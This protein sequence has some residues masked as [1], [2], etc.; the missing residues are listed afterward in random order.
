M[1]AYRPAS[2]FA[3]LAINSA[4]SAIK[5][6]YEN[7]QIPDRLFYHVWAHT[8]GVIGRATRIATALKLSTPFVTIVQTAAAK[9]DEVQLYARDRKVDGRVMRQRAIGAN[10]RQSGAAALKFI[11]Q[12]R[13]AEGAIL[14][15]ENHLILIEAILTT[16]PK[17]NSEYKTV[18][19]PALN[20]GS[21]PVTRAVA[22]ADLGAAGMDPVQFD[23]EGPA[24]FIED[25]IDVALMLSDARR[26]VDIPEATQSTIQCR[27]VQWMA[28]RPQFVQG[29]RLLLQRELEGL[30]APERTSIKLLFS[31][32]E[33]SLHIAEE[34][35]KK[36]ASMSFIDVARCL[37]P[38]A[39]P[40]EA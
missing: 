2:R 23:A 5:S 29:R 31:G 33:E 1:N 21:H 36:F 16:V 12:H 39:L 34:A 8:D 7:V 30:S 10:E 35:P 25:N 14:M 3:E 13:A 6:Q 26:L 15:D 11:R 24:L 37:I 32:F 19:Q 28:T 18:V 27:L 17:W 40:E 20:R 38:N 9:H 4:K 22:L